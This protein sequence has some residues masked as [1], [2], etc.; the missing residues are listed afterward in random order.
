MKLELKLAG[1]Q[2]KEAGYYPATC[3]DARVVATGQMEKDGTPQVLLE[4]DCSV[5]Y[6]DEQIAV[7]TG[8][9]LT[10]GPD[11]KPQGRTG[12]RGSRKRAMHHQARKPWS[13]A[14]LSLL[15]RMMT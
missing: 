3:N 8:Q 6:D 7:T 4:L 13:T 5:T 10:L 9:Y 14:R 11:S 15:P 1:A 12:N 2:I